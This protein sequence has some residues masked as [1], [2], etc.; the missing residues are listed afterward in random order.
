MENLT[1]EKYQQA[2]TNVR[3]LMKLKPSKDS[4]EGLE[5]ESLISAIENYE[6]I[7]VTMTSN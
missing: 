1:H 6:E 2:L 7:Y 5:L 4:V 3:M